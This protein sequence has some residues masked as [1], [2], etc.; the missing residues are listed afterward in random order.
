MWYCPS[1][2]T[3]HNAACIAQLHI[4]Y[5]QPYF[6][7]H[8]SLPSNTHWKL[9]PKHAC[10]YQQQIW[11]LPSTIKNKSSLAKS[12]I[13]C[14]KSL[15]GTHNSQA[16]IRKQHN[17]NDKSPTTHHHSPIISNQPNIT[18]HHSQ[19]TTCDVFIVK[20]GWR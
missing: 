4:R 3:L 17:T 2:D 7:A 11:M 5:S 16:I 12:Q 8:K 1:W 9:S 10:C 19:I 18:S 20:W 13:T 15:I 14:N 6:T